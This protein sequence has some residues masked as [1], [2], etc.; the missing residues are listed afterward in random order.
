M[1]KREDKNIN[2]LDLPL[3]ITEKSIPMIFISSLFWQFDT[4]QEKMFYTKGSFPHKRCHNVS[5]INI[6]VKSHS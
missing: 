4:D 2:F 5:L 3:L 1:L 6:F